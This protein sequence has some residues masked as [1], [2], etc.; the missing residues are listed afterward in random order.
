MS[1]SSCSF[2]LITRYPLNTDTVKVLLSLWVTDSGYNIQI[3]S[4]SWVLLLEQKYS[5]SYNVRKV[6]Y[7]IQKIIV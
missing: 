3:M 6:F 5:Y 4:V 2:F 1:V 7:V